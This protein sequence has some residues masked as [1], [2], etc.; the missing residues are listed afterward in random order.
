MTSIPE[1]LT[2]ALTHHR[3]GELDRAEQI[4]REV[5]QADPNQADALHLIGLIAH[6]N[7]RSREAIDYIGRAI[8]SNPNNAGFHCNIGEAHR[9]LMELDKAV[10]AYR[11]ALQ[12]RPDSAKAYSNLGVALQQQG[13]SL[14]AATSCRRAL[15]I[16]P[17]YAEAHGNLGAALESLNELD[18]AADSYRR[19]VQLK[20]DCVAAHYGLGNVLKAQEKFDEAA[21][22]YRQVLR[23][24]PEHVDAYIS[25]GNALQGAEKFDEAADSYRQALRIRPDFAEVH[26]NLGNTFKGQEKLDEAVESYHRA[27]KRK[28]DYAQ[29][30]HNLGK[31]LKEQGKLD[32][33]VASYERALQLDPDYA[34]THHNLAN[35]LRE[36]GKLDEAVSH[37]RKAAEL[38]PSKGAA[39]ANLAHSRQFTEADRGEIEHMEEVLRN[40]D[41]TQRARSQLHF[42][43][44]KAYDDCSRWGQAFAHYQKA[45]ELAAFPFNE[46]KIIRYADAVTET[47]S[48]TFPGTASDLGRDSDLPIFVLG[49]PRS[50]TT[51]VEQIIS[52]HP[53]VFGAG[54]LNDMA[55]TNSEVSSV[56]ASDRATPWS[57]AELD[58]DSSR[59]LA[60]RYLSKIRAL[61][62]D[63]RHITDKMPQNFLHLGLIHL[64]LP[65][66][67]IIH[68]RRHPL[69]VCLSCYFANFSEGLDF[70]F[71]L[72]NL[73]VYYRQYERLMDHWQ[74]VLPVSMFEVQ[75]EDL[76]ERQEEVS[77][78]IIDFCGL[79]WRR[80]CLDFHRNPR[81][82]F[83][84]SNWQVRQPMYT[85]SVGRWRHYDEFLDPLKKALG[86]QPVVPNE[87]K[88]LR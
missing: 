77:R 21:D 82:V 78:A 47:F 35:V 20:P 33:A 28:P 48:A 64:L 56:V 22:S 75:Y 24:R 42:A 16:N 18:E 29:A 73:G 34:M 40:E 30:H 41:L 11:R 84:A 4:Y 85:R 54:E 53:A 26:Y 36:Q 25:L 31:V 80:E 3:S 50:A 1:A 76:V 79:D 17:N 67:K 86:R 9:A 15:A 83:T 46:E 70:A 61:A 71:D 63:A 8:A 14:E 43:L 58:S 23:L 72:H 52:S 13:K 39:F 32:E 68:C 12:I 69:D 81:A 2:A 5:L 59:L 87:T 45:N 44:G 88:D 65:R 49:M 19:A 62:P 57:I 66:A 74:S 10:A 7:D 51:L 27:L 6:Q 38:D 37:L 55:T 60:D